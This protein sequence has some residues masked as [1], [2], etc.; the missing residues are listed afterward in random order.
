[1]RN[2]KNVRCLV[3]SVAALALTACGGGGGGD[4]VG[5][6]APPT[7]SPTNFV[8][9]VPKPTYATESLELLFFN[10]LNDVRNN[11]GVGLLAQ[12]TMLDQAAR[13]HSKY[14]IT[15]DVMGHD[16]DP[17]KPGFT[18]AGPADRTK[19]TGYTSG[20]RWWQV[21]EVISYDTLTASTKCVEG[22]LSTVFHQA[23]LI[24]YSYKDIGIAYT[25]KLT[26]TYGNCVINTGASAAQGNSP[27]IAPE[28]WIGVYP[29]NG[30]EVHRIGFSGE[31]P[32]PL[33]S[34]AVKG[35]AISI[36]ANKDWAIE[37]KTFTVSA[38]GQMIAVKLLGNTEF[39]DYLNKYILFALPVA[40]LTPGMTYQVHFEGTFKKGNASREVTKDWSFTTAVNATS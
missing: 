18:G 17:S 30:Q 36:H 37:A 32:D 25:D 22:L 11:Y 38:N 9:E 16:E 6:D 8:A 5:T 1:M 19:T 28:D 7:P 26:S 33:P 20:L 39:P 31:T 12:N 29:Y 40:P 21:G 3:A 23:L 13:N 24:D 27:Q 35:H 2:L 15:N 4:N 10:Q 14:Q 34:V